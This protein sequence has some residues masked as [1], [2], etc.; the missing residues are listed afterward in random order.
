MPSLL[1]HDSKGKAYTVIQQTYM[2]TC[3]PCSIAMVEMMYKKKCATGDP[4]ERAK[5]ISDWHE[6]EGMSFGMISAPLTKLSVKYS[7]TTANDPRKMFSLISPYLSD[8]TPAIVN[9]VHK[10]GAMNHIVVCAKIYG[11]GLGIFLD[12]AGKIVEVHE[13]SLP[14]YGFNQLGRFDFDGSAFMTLR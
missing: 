6:G 13:R 8:Q 11:D 14:A 4:E 12:P 7:F 9:L 5:S 10:G 1:L 2:T 3:G